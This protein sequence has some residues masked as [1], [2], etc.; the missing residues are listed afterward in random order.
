MKF[1]PCQTCGVSKPHSQ[2]RAHSGFDDGLTQHCRKCCATRERKLYAEDK[3]LR[4]PLAV[5]DRVAAHASEKPLGYIT[6]IADGMATVDGSPY[7]VHRLTF[8]PTRKQIEQ[9]KRQTVTWR[10]MKAL[11]AATERHR[12]PGDEDD[13]LD[14]LDLLLFPEPTTS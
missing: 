7:P 10:R 9:R 11:Q 6:A 2:F 1:K 14:E 3:E 5:G 8:L 12:W 4:E 13:R